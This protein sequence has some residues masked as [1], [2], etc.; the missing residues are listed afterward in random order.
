[1]IVLRTSFVFLF[2]MAVSFSVSAADIMIRMSQVQ[3]Y[4]LGIKMGIPEPVQ[5]VP[6]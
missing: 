5:Q 1:M 2:M 4:K 6:M 3:L